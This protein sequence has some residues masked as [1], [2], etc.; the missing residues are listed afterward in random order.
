M[1]E[2]A[3]AASS[4]VKPTYVSSATAWLFNTPPVDEKVWCVFLIDEA[5]LYTPADKHLWLKMTIL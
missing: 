4:S 5:Y 3:K 1:H 2:A